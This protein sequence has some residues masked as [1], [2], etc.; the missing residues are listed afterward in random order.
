MLMKVLICHSINKIFLKEFIPDIYQEY[1]SWK[2]KT[3]GS[4]EKLDFPSFRAWLD[5]DSVE[6]LS[7]ISDRIKLRIFGKGQTTS[8]I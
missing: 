3:L 8:L 5:T 2:A 4:S 7:R 6:N 1:F